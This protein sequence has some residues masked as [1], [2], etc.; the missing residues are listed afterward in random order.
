[1]GLRVDTLVS[2]KL[3]L[4]SYAFK[5]NGTWCCG[6]M[7]Q[8]IAALGNKGQQR[9]VDHTV[10]SESVDKTENWTWYPFSLDCF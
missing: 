6:K 8:P 3:R 7:S 1:M 2:E 9:L 10:G 5:E 4:A